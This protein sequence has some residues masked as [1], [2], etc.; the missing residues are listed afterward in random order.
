MQ[1]R[2]VPTQ[3]LTFNSHILTHRI[4]LSHRLNQKRL[5]P[6]NTIATL[7]PLLHRIRV[8]SGSWCNPCVPLRDSS[9]PLT[10]TKNSAVGEDGRR[11]TRTYRWQ[12]VAVT[13]SRMNCNVTTVEGLPSSTGLS[14]S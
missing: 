4:L 2:I 11:P 9:T 3:G 14:S 7:H 5:Q 12:M 10:I 13:G 8:H 6:I 1:Q